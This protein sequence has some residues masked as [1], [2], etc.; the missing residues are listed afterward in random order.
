MAANKSNKYVDVEV[1]YSGG[2]RYP[3]LC[4]SCNQK[5]VDKKIPFTMYNKFY[6]RKIILNFPVCEDCYQAKGSYVNVVPVIAI[7]SIV[8]ILSLFTIINQPEYVPF[9]PTIH[10]I[11]GLVWLAIIVG[12]VLLMIKKA[13][14]K[15]S[16]DVKSRYQNLIKAVK[17]LQFQVSRKTKKKKLVLGFTNATFAK[18]FKKINQG[19]FAKKP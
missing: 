10:L 12:Y 5:A 4:V 11:A 7:G 9:S 1:E 19:K 18:E 14:E 3:G 17:G 15:N 8:F 16:E 13:K 2:L 6:T